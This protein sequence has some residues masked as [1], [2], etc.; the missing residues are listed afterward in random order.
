METI[1]M[2]AHFGGGADPSEDG[3]PRSR[4]IGGDPLDV[5]AR[6][7]FGKPA[8]LVEIDFQDHRPTLVEL[9]LFNVLLAESMRQLAA[10]PERRSFAA[11]AAL[12][13]R[14][15]GQGAGRSSARLRQALD[16]L[17][18]PVR[19]PRLGNGLFPPLASWAMPDQETVA[20]RLEDPVCALLHRSEVWAWLDLG[21]SVEFQRTA[22]LLLYERLRLIANRRWP[23]LSLGVPELRGA[24]GLAG[25][26]T[27][28]GDLLQK[29]VMPAVREIEALCALSVAVRSEREPRHRMLT[30]L[31]FKLPLDRGKA[32]RPAASGGEHANP[33][34]RNS[35][36]AADRLPAPARG[37]A[38]TPDAPATPGAS[39]P[40]ARLPETSRSPKAALFDRGID[41]LAAQGIGEQAARSFL[42]LLVRKYDDGFVAVVLDAA[43]KQRET[44]V[45]LRSW[46]LKRLK[47]YPTRD[48]EH[49]AGKSRREGQAPV[50]RRPL[51]T[52]EN[53]GISPGMAAKIQAR[54][55]WLK[56]FNVLDGPK[57]AAPGGAEAG[58]KSDP[59]AQAAQSTVAVDGGNE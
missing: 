24:L 27:R 11:R 31:T 59:A 20:W 43:W 2:Q 25:R 8:E 29:T 49:L 57:A 55:R 33:P 28:G 45:D 50:S 47:R 4:L 7:S 30:R 16:R 48:D 14:A 36:P 52:P 32:S 10:D 5:G 37:I 23:V 15:I 39:I 58:G 44:L 6:R 35:G 1:V 18:V 9:K 51:A 40:V 38:R 13:R 54:N 22:S 12:L 26:M 46:V 42:G 34:G 3:V 21:L 53:L 56:D 41:M 17:R 19:M